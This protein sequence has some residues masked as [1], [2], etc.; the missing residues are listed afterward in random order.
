MADIAAF[1]T[2]R[3]VFDSGAENFITMT[4]T[5]AVKAGMVVEIDA[6][7]VDLAVNAAVKES[8]A[9]PVGVA[10]YDAAAGS[11][12]AVA[13][14]GA[15]VYVA[16]AESNVDIDAGDLLVTNDNTVGGTVSASVAVGTTSTPQ[17]LIGIAIDDIDRSTTGRC[18]ITL[19]HVTAHA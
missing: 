6:T 9:S 12:V 11:K 18:L 14:I 17:K 1:P 16:N 4:A 8:G 2:I 13:T 5:N 3:K 7:G 19:G 10:L 15:V